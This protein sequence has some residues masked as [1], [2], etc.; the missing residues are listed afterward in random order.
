V[1]VTSR[2]S[3][4]NPRRRLATKR[5]RIF[6]G[7]CD[8][9]H[10]DRIAGPEYLEAVRTSFADYGAAL[11]ITKKAA[12]KAHVLVADALRTL[13]RAMTAYATQVVA[14]AEDS[15]G[16][17]RSAWRAALTPFD[18]HRAGLNR[19]KESPDAAPAEDPA[20]PLPPAPAG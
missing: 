18:A 16:S 19:R 3:T 13:S 20:A 9:K 12:D 5:R 15:E 4:I 7:R 6:E 11:G 17:A 1:Q 8:R 14:A 10:I 2:T